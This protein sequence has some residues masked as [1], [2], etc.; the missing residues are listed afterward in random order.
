MVLGYNKKIVYSFTLYR[1]F[2]GY[3]WLRGYTL[4]PCGFQVATAGDYT[5]IKQ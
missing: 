4:E 2:S 1:D 5:K 3:I